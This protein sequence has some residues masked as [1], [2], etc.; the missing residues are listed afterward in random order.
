MSYTIKETLDKLK[1]SKSELYGLLALLR[2]KPEKQGGKSYLS[3]EQIKQIQTYMDDSTQSAQFGSST[4]THQ[5][6]ETMKQQHEA[7]IK[8]L[9]DMYGQQQTILQNQLD[10]ERENNQQLTLTL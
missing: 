1:I 2:I 10:K 9:E 5:L 6:L 4:D 7:E 8:R 3:P